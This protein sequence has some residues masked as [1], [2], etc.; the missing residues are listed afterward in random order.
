MLPLATITLDN[1]RNDLAT[2]INNSGGIPSKDE[3]DEIKREN[4]EEN[5]MDEDS[6]PVPKSEFE[7]VEQDV[8][9]NGSDV[10]HVD[11]EELRV[12]IPRNRSSPYD[13]EWIE[14]TNDNINEIE[15]KDYDILAFTTGSDDQFAIVEAAYDG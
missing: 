4:E 8:S 7:V 12:A 3:T 2:A 14:L 13:N 10:Q 11:P 9:V 6:I 1:I 15:F 5:L